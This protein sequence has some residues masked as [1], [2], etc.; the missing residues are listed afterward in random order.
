MT[1]PVAFSAFPGELFRAPRTWAQ[2]AYP[3]LIYYNKPAR[4]GHFAA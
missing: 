4:R 1:V 2:K 3:T